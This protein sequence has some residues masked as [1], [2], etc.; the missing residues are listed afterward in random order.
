M[1]TLSS[2]VRNLPGPSRSLRS[3]HGPGGFPEEPWATPNTNYSFYDATTSPTGP[4]A[5][6]TDQ[7]RN[8]RRRRSR[9]FRESIAD[10][11]ANWYGHHPPMELLHLPSEIPMEIETILEPS[12]ER[13]QDRLVEEERVREEQ[14]RLEKEA[15]L[16]LNDEVS[17]PRPTEQKGKERMVTPETRNQN[18]EVSTVSCFVS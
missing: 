16:G 17:L 9:I 4:V 14:R 6:P 12:I 18:H 7:D 13:V 5:G 3:R 11:E 10:K 2:A 15:K 8:L 1:A